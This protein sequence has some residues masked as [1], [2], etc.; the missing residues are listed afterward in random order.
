MRKTDDL[1]EN[2][3]ESALDGSCKGDQEELKSF[4]NL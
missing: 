1:S 2:G 3:C 4:K